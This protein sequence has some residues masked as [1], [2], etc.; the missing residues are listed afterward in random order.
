MTALKKN[1]TWE[2]VPPQARQNVVGS[3]WVFCL[4]EKAD[5]TIERYKDR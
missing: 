2:L 3:K 5:G 1:N 4:K